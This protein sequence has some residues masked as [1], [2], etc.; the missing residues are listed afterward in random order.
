[1]TDLELALNALRV[2]ISIIRQ[3]YERMT[4]KEYADLKSLIK[5]FLKDLESWVIQPLH[6]W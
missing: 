4:P 3:D 2:N 1:M 5:R 6:N